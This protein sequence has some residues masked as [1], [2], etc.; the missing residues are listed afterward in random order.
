MGLGGGVQEFEHGLFCAVQVDAPLLGAG[1][2]GDVLDQPG[3]ASQ[4]VGHDLAGGFVPSGDPV[5]ET[6]AVHGEHRD[7]GAH[8][9]GQV[10]EHPP[11][12][13]F[14]TLQTS[15]HDVERGGHPVHLR[16]GTHGRYPGV[17]AAAG[18][19]FGGFGQ[20][21]ERALDATG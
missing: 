20:L 2:I 16:S 4:L 11:A 12:G 17:V 7:R 3:E 9:M 5:L 15:R 13:A 19:A 14:G 1:D 21:P 18:H 6:F 10:R 8:L